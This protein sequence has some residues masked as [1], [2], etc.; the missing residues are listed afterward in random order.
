MVNGGLILCPECKKNIS[1]TASSCPKCGYV[2]TPE[3]MAEIKNKQKNFRKE[4]REPME[5][6]PMESSFSS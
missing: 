1:E 5:S 6:E 4:P 3:K 2:L